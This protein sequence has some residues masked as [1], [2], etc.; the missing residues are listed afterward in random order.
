MCQVTSL[1]LLHDT[2]TRELSSTTSYLLLLQCTYFYLLHNFHHIIACS[3]CHYRW[4]ERL[5][6]CATVNIRL[7]VEVHLNPS[8]ILPHL[9]PNTRY[10]TINIVNQRKN[11]QTCALLTFCSIIPTIILDRSLVCKFMATNC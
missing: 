6:C 7:D 11:G 3:G 1:L 2:S 5:L 4:L 9:S 8:E 10:L